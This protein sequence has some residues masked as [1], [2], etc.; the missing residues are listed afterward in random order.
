MRFHAR[1]DKEA[2][3]HT[4]LTAFIDD[5]N[6]GRLWMNTKEVNEL[7]PILR[8]ALL[9]NGHTYQITEPKEGK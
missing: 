3:K 6:C 7:L 2:G 5:T 1:I 8:R 9:D 4:R